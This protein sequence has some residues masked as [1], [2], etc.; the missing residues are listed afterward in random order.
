[1][2][3]IRIRVEKANIDVEIPNV[4][5]ALVVAGSIAVAGTVA[6][7][8][9]DKAPPNVTFDKNGVTVSRQA[10]PPESYRLADA[11]PPK[12]VPPPAA[13]VV[14]PPD[15]S[16]AKEAPKPRVENPPM[17]DPPKKPVKKR[18]RT[19]VAYYYKWVRAQG[20]AGETP[21]VKVKMKCISRRQPEI[22]SKPAWYRRKNPLWM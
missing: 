1:M 7:M 4:V 8:Y 14:T 22:C 5:T 18:K 3:R 9:R 13:P 10:P 21:F 11:E 20:D 15:V 6:Y 19:S 2:S 16:A 12:P 17:T